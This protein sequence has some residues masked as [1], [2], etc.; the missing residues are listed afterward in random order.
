[1]PSP[2][3][4]AYKAGEDFLVFSTVLVIERLAPVSCEPG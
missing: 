4:D 3:T 2:D 1:M